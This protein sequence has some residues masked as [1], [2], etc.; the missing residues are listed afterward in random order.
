VAQRFTKPVQPGRPE[1]DGQV[2]ERHA[3]ADLL[4]VELHLVDEV[5][6]EERDG[7]ELG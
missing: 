6:R 7:Q 1:Q 2:E 3:D 4:V 5:E